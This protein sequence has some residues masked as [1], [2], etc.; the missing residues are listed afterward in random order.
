MQACAPIGEETGM[1]AFFPISLE[2]ANLLCQEASQITESILDIACIN[3]PKQIVLS[4]SQV[5]LNKAIE[6]ARQGYTGDRCKASILDVSAPFHSSYMKK[7]EI[8]IRKQLDSMKIRVTSAPIISNMTV[9]PMRTP[10]EIRENVTALTSLPVRFSECVEKSIS[11]ITSQPSL[12]VIPSFIELGPQQTLTNFVA[13]TNP[14][15]QTQ[16]L[17]SAESITKFFSNNDNLIAKSML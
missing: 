9:M 10:E 8:A 14:S 5:A 2:Q 15:V 12:D 7:S 4:G 11:M 17:G 16:F 1:A 6:L 13:Q 3:S